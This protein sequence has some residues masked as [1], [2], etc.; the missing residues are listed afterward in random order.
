LR[1]Y[2]TPAVWTTRWWVTWVFWHRKF[3]WKHK[4]EQY[5]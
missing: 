2:K 1:W 4:K 3:C 5:L